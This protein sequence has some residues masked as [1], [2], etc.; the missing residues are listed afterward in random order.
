MAKDINDVVLEDVKERLRECVAYAGVTGTLD[1]LE[2]ICLETAQKMD[3]G[4]MHTGES[5]IWW[6][7][8]NR[9]A[10]CIQAIENWEFK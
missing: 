8:T 4:R 3:E 6:M 2:E 5:R 1:V 10:D 7:F 9:I